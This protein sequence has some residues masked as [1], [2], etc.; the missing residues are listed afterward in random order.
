MLENRIIDQVKEIIS[1]YPERGSALMPALDFVQEARGGSLSRDDLADVAAVVGVPKSRAF[2]V[3]SFYS[4]YRKEPP[5]REAC[6]VDRELPGGRSEAARLIGSLARGEMPGKPSQWSVESMCGI[7]IRSRGGES[8]PSI[9]DY[10]AAGGYAALDKAR[11]MGADA[12]RAEVEASGLRGRG[13]A[14]FPAGTKWGFVSRAKGRPVYLICNADEGEPGT[15]KDR[16][17]M[18]HDPHLHIE[19]MAIAALALGAAMGFIYIRGESASIARLLEKAVAEAEARGRIGRVPGFEIKVHRGAGSYI[20]GEETA[21]IESLEGKR[22]HPRLKPPF[23][24]E[25]GLYGCPTIV[26]NVETLAC[27]PFIIGKGAAAFR[28]IGAA[29]DCGPRIFSVSGHVRRPGVYE[30]PTGTPLRELLDL[31]GGVEGRLKA[32]IVGG[33]STPILTAEEARSLRLDRDS[34]QRAGTMPGSGGVIVF[35]EG[36]D[37][38]S[39][40]LETIRFYA[41]ESCG[42][43]TPCR[44]GAHVISCLLEK[45]VD[46]EA[47]EEE[48]ET[49]VRLCR[50][51]K[52]TT[53]CPMGDSFSIAIEA[54]ITKFGDEFAP[55]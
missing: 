11:R 24:A 22:G 43:C 20:C 55:R 33:L 49:I 42:Q 45:A 34:C 41:S 53:L 38:P 13:G 5:G 26:N 35:A 14:G 2:A 23:P 51:I 52:G 16:H 25:R 28:K 36:A 8:S 32:V 6:P 12:V 19:G 47:S 54:M 37:V 9:D 3:F 15:F 48:V 46:R 17:I 1:R 50:T 39:I 7:L 29:G 27:L 10:V 40:A 30:C 21:L 4:M 18:E 44:E 31:A